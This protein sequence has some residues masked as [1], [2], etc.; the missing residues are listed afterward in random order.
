MAPHDRLLAIGARGDQVDR[1]SGERL[2]ALEI[3][4]RGL[5]QLVVGLDADGALHPAR[6]LLVARVAAFE[7]L[8]ADRQDV[9]KRAFELVAYADLHRLDAIEHIELGDAQARNAIELD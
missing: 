7:L 9:R 5:G 4:A 6:Q 3:R 2:D 8:G 1:Y